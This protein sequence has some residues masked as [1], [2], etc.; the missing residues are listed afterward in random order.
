MIL[1]AVIAAAAGV[2]I[3]VGVLAGMRVEGIVGV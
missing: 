3:G 1:C 2:L